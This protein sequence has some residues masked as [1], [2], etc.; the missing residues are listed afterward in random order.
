MSKRQAVPFD[1]RRNGDPI[2]DV[3]ANSAVD[4]HISYSIHF[5][6]WEAAVAAGA[7]LDE[8]MRLDKYPIEFRAKLVAWH[9]Y[10][11]LVELHAQDAAVP[12]GK[13]K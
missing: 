13:N 6:E 5:S 11:K 9:G 1:V 8:L 10:H 3:R 2:E 4:P 12:K 7:S